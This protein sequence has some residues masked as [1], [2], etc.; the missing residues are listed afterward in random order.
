MFVVLKKFMDSISRLFCSLVIISQLSIAQEG[1]LSIPQPI[2]MKFWK[3]T[4][5][6][7]GRLAKKE[8]VDKGSAPFSLNTEGRIII[9][10][11]M[12]LPVC[13]ILKKENKEIPVIIIQAE[14]VAY[15]Q[16]VFGAIDVFSGA[17]HVFCDEDKFEILEKPNNLFFK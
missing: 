11:N 15:V 3:I 6:I 13:A 9:P 2:D 5:C 17:F 10:I 14:E 12:C 7:K 8:E 4:P 16:K 1:M